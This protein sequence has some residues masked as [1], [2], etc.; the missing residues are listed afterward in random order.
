MSNGNLNK[1]P[2]L[3]AE[4]AKWDAILA[5]EGLGEEPTPE[6]NE[7]AHTPEFE[8]AVA[9]LFRHYVTTA[10]SE[11][12]VHRQELERIRAGFGGSAEELDLL[13]EDFARD[14]EDMVGNVQKFAL[15]VASE[16]IQARPMLAG[17]PENVLKLVLMQLRKEFE[18][19]D[20]DV[21]A[22]V[23]EQVTAQTVH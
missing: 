23:A 19:I 20:K 7:E 17:R 14:V 15:E 4:K 2:D 10:T 21:L 6:T 11:Y 22:L 3:K 1:K 9:E 16:I 8:A 12:G 13:T 5:A 18:T